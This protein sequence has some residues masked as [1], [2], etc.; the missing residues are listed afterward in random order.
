[1][2]GAF[3]SV[4]QVA[5]DHLRGKVVRENDRNT[6]FDGEVAEDETPRRGIVEVNEGGLIVVVNFLDQE[7]IG[8]DKA[9]VFPNEGRIRGEKIMSNAATHFLAPAGSG[10]RTDDADL[11]VGRHP[12]EKVLDNGGD[13][14]D[15][16]RVAITQVKDPFAT[17]GHGCIILGRCQLGS[18]KRKFMR[19]S[20]Q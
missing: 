11:I 18:Q 6:V 2:S 1:M 7:R 14:A 20:G 15:C 10:A 13:P 5:E 4:G 3:N 8:S 19:D 12:T 9:D 16:P 17:R